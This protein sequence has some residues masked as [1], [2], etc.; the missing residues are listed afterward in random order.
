MI[1]K[2][3]F[4]QSFAVLPSFVDDEKKRDAIKF[5]DKKINECCVMSTLP[6]AVLHNTVQY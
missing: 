1:V 5:C 2:W 4:G 6:L 3:L